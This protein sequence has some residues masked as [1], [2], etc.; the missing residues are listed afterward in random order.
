MLSSEGHDGHGRRMVMITV[1][2]AAMFRVVMDGVWLLEAVI[3]DDVD[4]FN[5][6]CKKGV[7]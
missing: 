2:L 1:F 5:V 4:V 3:R 6:S 7:D